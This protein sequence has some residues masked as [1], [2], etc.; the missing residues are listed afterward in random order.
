MVNRIQQIPQWQYSF[1]SNSNDEIVFF[2]RL[3]KS[4]KLYLLK[5]VTLSNCIFRAPS[6]LPGDTGRIG[7]IPSDF[8]TLRTKL[9]SLQ[10]WGNYRTGTIPS[11]LSALSDLEAFSFQSND[12][13][14]PVSDEFNGMTQ[15]TD[16]RLSENYLTGSIPPLPSSLSV[17]SNCWIDASSC[18]TEL[19]ALG[20]LLILI[21]LYSF[22]STQLTKIE[23]GSIGQAERPRETVSPTRPLQVFATSAPS[24]R[25]TK[26]HPYIDSFVI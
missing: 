26:C 3:G 16:F 24:V 14:G 11:G 20:F 10:L 13:I 22:I 4:T 7:S 1:I 2:L 17:P 12:L 5:G 6:L 25:S 23:T 9:N 21:V 15:L 19:F 8:W 18:T